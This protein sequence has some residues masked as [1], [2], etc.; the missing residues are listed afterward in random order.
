MTHTLH[1]T[2]P[3]VISQEDFTQL[4]QERLRQA[5]C[6]ALIDILEEEMIAFIG[7]TPEN[8]SH[9]QRD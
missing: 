8:D 9:Q 1:N 3:S 5:V 4:V 6:L 7:A 2:N